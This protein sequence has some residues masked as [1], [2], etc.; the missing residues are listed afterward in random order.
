[1]SVAPPATGVYALYRRGR[2][3]YAGKALKTTLKTRLGQHYKKIAGRQNIS[4][5]DMTCRYLE[6]ESPWFVRAAEDALIDAYRERG[7]VEWNGTGFGPHDPGSGR[8]GI[9]TSKWDGWF[10]PRREADGG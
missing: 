10:P 9:R 8:P 2:L 1:M 6:I 4:T 5:S 3:V 7:L